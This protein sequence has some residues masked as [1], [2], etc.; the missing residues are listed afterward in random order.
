VQPAEAPAAESSVLAQAAD[1]LPRLI[2]QA[3]SALT[4]ATT[5]GEVL[6]AHDQAAMAYDAAKITARRAKLKDA[7]DVVLAACH[8]AQ[9]DALV[10]EA[11]AKYRL[12]D[13]Y[14]AA[15]ERGEVKKAGNKSGKSTISNE[16][17][18]P[19]VT[20]LG[21]TSKQVHD[22]R[23]ARDAEQ[24]DPGIVQRTVDAKL[25]AG[26]EPTRA[27]VRRAV[28][29]TTAARTAEKSGIP[30]RKDGSISAS[31]VTAIDILKTWLAAASD[32]QTRAIN[33][34]GRPLLARIPDNWVD[35]VDEWLTARR[36][37][38]GSA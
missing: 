16:N 22:A 9:G 37:H 19:T 23:Q 11:R 21:L 28:K 3:A 12:A 26:E 36:P 24:A 18:T 33:L 35:A 25:K 10:I 17:N 7:Y 5:A 8:R 32:E 2:K 1:R 13:E 29:R 14:D 6:E 38:R 31:H 27:A 34:I 4:K 20:D 30:F 15:Q